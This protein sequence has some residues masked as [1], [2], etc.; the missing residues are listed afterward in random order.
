MRPRRLIPQA[1]AILKEQGVEVE[2]SQVAN[3]GLVVKSGDVVNTDAF[4][5]GL[6]TIQDESAMLAVESMTINP[7][8][9]VLDACAAPGGKPSRL[10]LP[11]MKNRVAALRP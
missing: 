6:V 9:Q 4:M 8:D 10:R 5:Q 11:W 2:P 1:I 7:A 3:D